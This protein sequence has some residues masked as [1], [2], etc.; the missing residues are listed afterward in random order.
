VVGTHGVRWM[1][2]TWWWEVG[3]TR[4]SGVGGLAPKKQILS[5]WAQ[6]WL[7]SET[8]SRICCGD[9]WREVDVG[10]CGGGRWGTRERAGRGD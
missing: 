5:V 8:V 10:K 1:Q 3:N 4:T 7:G 9:P 2:E 6:Y